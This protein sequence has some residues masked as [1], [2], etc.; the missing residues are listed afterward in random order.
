MASCGSALPRLMAGLRFGNTRFWSLHRAARYSPLASFIATAPTVR[1]TSHDDSQDSERDNLGECS[2]NQDGAWCR[3]GGDDGLFDCRA[4]VQCDQGIATACW[5]R[6]ASAGRD[7]GYSVT[8]RCDRDGVL[9]RLLASF[10][11]GRALWRAESRRLARLRRRGCAPGES[12]CGAT[13]TLIVAAHKI[14]WL[15]W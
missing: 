13:S 2:D 11:V 1:S 12:D 7:C 14:L 8:W 5:R 4:Q 9:A 10:L 3:G 15:G 6:G